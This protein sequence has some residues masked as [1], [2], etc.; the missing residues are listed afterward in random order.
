VLL[1]Q[2]IRA[3]ADL[4]QESNSEDQARPE[5]NERD[6]GNRSVAKFFVTGVETTGT[7][8]SRLMRRHRRVEVACRTDSEPVVRRALNIPA[9]WDVVDTNKDM[10]C[11]GEISARIREAKALEHG[12]AGEE[13]GPA[14]DDLYLRADV[15]APEQHLPIDV[16]EV[17]RVVIDGSGAAAI[18]GRRPALRSRVVASTQSRPWRAWPRKSDQLG[19]GAVA[20]LLACRR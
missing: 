7:S 20:A 12:R 4:P 14:R 16:R 1:G 11:S 6:R 5:R 2:R 17:S 13:C 9:G 19:I 18:A 15:R 10:V 8:L 3:A